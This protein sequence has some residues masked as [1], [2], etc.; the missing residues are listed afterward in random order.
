MPLRFE[1]DPRK[2]AAN[3]RKHGVTFE[4]ATDVWSD[5]F[6]LDTP[7]IDHSVNDERY[8]AVGLSQRSRVP[9]VWYADRGDRIRLISARFANRSERRRYE[10]ESS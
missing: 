5:A 1:W 10:E 6:A 9:V 4:E 3:V 7:D 8:V 2:A